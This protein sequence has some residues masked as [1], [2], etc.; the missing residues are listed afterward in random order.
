VT[1][2][3]RLPT[4]ATCYLPTILSRFRLLGGYKSILLPLLL[5]VLLLLLLLLLYY[6]NNNNNKASEHVPSMKFCLFVS[7]RVDIT[8]FSLNLVSKLLYSEQ[9]KVTSVWKTFAFLYLSSLTWRVN[10]RIRNIAKYVISKPIPVDAQSKAWVCGC[11]LVGILSS[12]PAGA[13]DV[14]LFWVFYVVR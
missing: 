3:G 12:N 2:A 13:S 11:L 9:H 7:N 14:C 8:L 6:L 5:L 1:D 10:N 4:V